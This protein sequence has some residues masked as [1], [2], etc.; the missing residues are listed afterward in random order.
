MD[1]PFNAFDASGPP[2]VK[3]S[4]IY[5][6]FCEKETGAIQREDGKDKGCHVLLC[7]KTCPLTVPFLERMF[8]GLSEE[9]QVVRE[10]GKGVVSC[11][12]GK[13]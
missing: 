11:F 9:K 12:E 5:L 10:G 7:Q 3:D 6:F 13:W 2:T 4:L 1:S 8:G